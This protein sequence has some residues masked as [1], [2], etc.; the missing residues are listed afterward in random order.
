MALYTT[1][2]KF[3]LKGKEYIGTYNLGPDE[4]YYTGTS[5]I[6]GISNTL[7]PIV[8]GAT[9]NRVGD[10]AY[11]ALESEFSVRTLHYA[12]AYYPVITDDIYETGFVDRYFCQQWNDKVSNVIE[13]SKDQSKVVDSGFYQILSIK[14]AI[15]GEIAEV[16]EANIRSAKVLAKTMPAITSKLN[17]PTELY[18]RV[19]TDII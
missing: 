11:D 1:G 16:S 3:T 12:I 14:W 17:S 15:S 9:T 2:N 6:F 8:T 13:I 5:Y 19:Y 7:T 10:E 18:T 4:S